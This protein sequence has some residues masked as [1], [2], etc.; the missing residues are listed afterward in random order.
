[1]YWVYQDSRPPAAKSNRK[2]DK[3]QKKD[4]TNT[5]SYYRKNQILS[6]KKTVYGFFKQ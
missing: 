3:R 1:M 6:F 5:S 4:K 2:L